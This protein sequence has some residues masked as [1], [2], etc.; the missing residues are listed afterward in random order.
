MHFTKK[1]LC[2]EDKQFTSIIILPHTAVRIYYLESL[3][4]MLE[5]GNNVVPVKS[6][7]DLRF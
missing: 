3:Y 5:I 6:I 1:G 7:R 2:F 4:G